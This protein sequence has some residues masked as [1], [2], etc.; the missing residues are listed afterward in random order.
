MA[1]SPGVDLLAAISLCIVLPVPLMLRDF[2]FRGLFN[3][4]DFKV[5]VFGAFRFAA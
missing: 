5:N 1:R 4:N 3:W 2:F